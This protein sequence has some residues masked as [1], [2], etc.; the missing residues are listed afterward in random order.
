MV[1]NQIGAK[2]KAWAITKIAVGVVAGVFL[3]ALGLSAAF[4]NLNSSNFVASARGAACN[5]GYR[6]GYVPCN[7]PTTIPGYQKI[8]GA[9]YS[10]Y[11]AGYLACNSQVTLPGYS[12]NNVCNYGS[13]AGYLPC[14]YL[15]TTPG[16][17][18]VSAPVCY[19]GS[20]AG[21]TPCA[22]PATIPGYS[23]E[24]LPTFSVAPAESVASYGVM[25][26]NVGSVIIFK[27][28]TAY[29]NG[30]QWKLL[31]CETNSV[32]G[33]N[34]VGRTWCKSTSFVNTGMQNS[35][36]YITQLSDAESKVWYAYACNSTS[37]SAAS[38]GSGNSGSP[39][40][41]NHAP[42]FTK[43]YNNSPKAPGQKV[44][45]YATASD[46]DRD[47]L[48][49]SVRIYVCKTQAFTGGA[50]PTCAGGEWCH[51]ANWA[52]NPF[53]A[54][55]IPTSAADGTNNAYGYIVDRHGFVSSDVK[56]GTN[57]AFTV[58]H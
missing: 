43:Y 16:Y 7:Y 33:T 2:T 13:R 5:P 45:F 24:A 52:N 20:R 56:Q 8:Y 49:D 14:D 21:Y 29:T 15:T 35:C 39:F 50:N 3:V 17:S 48:V 32:S 46:S 37:C 25:P 31:V 30:E 58:R 1:V 34:C 26:T 9:C 22:Y 41:V 36:S 44:N 53:C 6:A 51:S 42:A 4:L 18:V 10:G 28:T 55:A 54:Y 40:K 47:T 57:S 12:R 23:D 38:G 27:A 19:P 11:R